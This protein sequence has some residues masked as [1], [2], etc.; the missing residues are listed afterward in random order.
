MP[1]EVDY[2]RAMLPDPPAATLED[3]NAVMAAVLAELGRREVADE[4]LSRRRQ[5]RPWKH[6]VMVGAVVA[7]ILAAVFAPLPHVSLFKHLIGPAQPV[8]A[9]VPKS[10][11]IGIKV[12]GWGFNGPNAIAAAGAHLWVANNGGNSV[13]EL[14][15]STGAVVKVLSGPS[16]G[17]NGPNAIAVGGGHVWVANFGNSGNSTVT[18]LSASTGAVVKVLSGPSY[19]FHFNGSSTIAVG[20]GHVWVANTGGASVTELNESTGTLVQVL[21]RPSYEFNRPDAIAADGT[22]VWVANADGESVTELTVK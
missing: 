22:H 3:R 20:G 7:V 18:E 9:T 6:R 19:G 8:P 16:Y 14:S 11:P 10:P 4:S 15:A 2:V 1:S 17:F 13:T 21:S 5:P 12:L